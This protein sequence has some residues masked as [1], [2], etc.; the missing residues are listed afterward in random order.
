MPVLEG[1][2]DV[3][4]GAAFCVDTG[5]IELDAEPARRKIGTCRYFSSCM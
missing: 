2:A 1:G 5:G 4:G 3:V